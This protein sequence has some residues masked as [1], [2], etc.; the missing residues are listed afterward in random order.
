MP[1]AVPW[2]RR[3]SPEFERG[4]LQFHWG[5][6][7]RLSPDDWWIDFAVLRGGVPIGMQG[8]SARRFAVLRT[9]G[10]G[11]WLGLE[12]QGRG[13]GKEMRAAV[14]GFAFE[15]L[16]AEEAHTSAFTDNPASEGVSRSLGYVEN[17]RDRMAPEGI[18]KEH[19]R[20]RMTK[21]LWRSRPRPPIE[22]HG[23]E[24]CRAL[25]GGG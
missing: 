24:A 3:P 20:F 15:R 2:T 6:R 9:V 21:E 5:Q 22:V 17:G 18:A 1:F 4:F 11:S 13:H 25:L 7:A 10:T 16:V 14:L 12:H 19:V 23:L 8:L